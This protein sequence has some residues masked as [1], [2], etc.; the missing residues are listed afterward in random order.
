MG[1]RWGEEMTKP[2]D[3]ES[4]WMDKMNCILVNAI[5]ECMYNNGMT[6]EC[7]DRAYEFIERFYRK[8]AIIPK[9]KADH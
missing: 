1:R 5:S 9:P 2:D 4:V 7:L 8:N 3:L 6:L